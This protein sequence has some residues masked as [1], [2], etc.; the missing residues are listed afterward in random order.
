MAFLVADKTYTLYGLTIHEKIL[1][2]SMR[3][4][5]LLSS[6]TGKVEYVT[7]HNTDDINEAKGT[8]DAEQYARAT[9][10][11]NMGGVTVHYYIDETAC[12]HI[13]PDNEVA[14]HAADG[15]YGPGN[16]STI[17]IE[18]VMDG[19]GKDY[20]IK[21]EDRGARLAAIKLYENN[22][23][24]DRL[25][26]HNRWYSKKYCPTYIL[27]HWNQFKNKVEKYL[28][29][30]IA[31]E[32][33]TVETKEYDLYRVQ[34]GAFTIEDNAHNFS[35]DLKRKGFDAF[36]VKGDDKYFRVQ[37]GAFSIKANAEAYVLSLKAAEFDAFI[38][39]VDKEGKLLLGDIDGDGKITAADARL[40]L[41]ASVGTEELTAEEFKRADMD[42]DGKI[43]A[44][45]ARTILRKSVELE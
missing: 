15:Y 3:P 17:A 43:T 11:G 26:T 19:S 12:W 35:E 30:L 18:I 20:D 16:N 28:N 39:G 40:A 22:L 1:P 44:A 4:N 9:F 36:V 21:A 10:N 29:E 24:I 7:I 37:V 41:R 33:K 25:T 14:Y 13:V 27:P 31:A 32:N 2:T 34:V 23:G 38:I 45:D 5:R 8:N 6:G 42:G